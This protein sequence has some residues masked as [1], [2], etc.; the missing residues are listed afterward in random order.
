[1][2]LTLPEIFCFHL[3]TNLDIYGFADILVLIEFFFPRSLLLSWSPI[4]ASILHFPIHWP[5][6]RKHRFWSM[7][8]LGVCT[9]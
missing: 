6:V 3:L 7:Q 8:N 9:P 1:M 2:R 5:F 4:Q